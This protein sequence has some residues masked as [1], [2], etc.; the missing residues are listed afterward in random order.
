MFSGVAERAFGPTEIRIM[1]R[2]MSL[3][4]HSLRL[5]EAGEKGELLRLVAQS[6]LRQTA[7]GQS[8]PLMIS[9]R[10]LREQRTARNQTFQPYNR[11]RLTGH[12][13]AKRARRIP[14][15]RKIA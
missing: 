14:R 12:V 4:T 1:Q 13:H 6:I 15:L 2:A 5:E 8:D 10:A 3:A 11:R 7:S 9:V